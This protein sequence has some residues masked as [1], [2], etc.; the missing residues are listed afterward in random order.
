MTARTGETVL[1]EGVLNWSRCER[2]GNRYGCFHLESPPS[3]GKY[4]AWDGAPLGQQ[5]TLTAVIVET[6]QSGHIGDIFLSVG[7]TTP[8]VGERVTLGAGTLFTETDDGVPQI[9]LQPDDGRDELWLDVPGLYRC[10]NQTV[11][12]IFT[13][14]SI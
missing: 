9:G 7:P 2:I 14:Q 8:E 12:L 4:S 5:G 13:P 6:R 10:H 3:S 11:R 1:G